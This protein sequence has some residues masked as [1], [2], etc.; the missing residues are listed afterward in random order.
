M[1]PP[2]SLLESD[3]D[4]DI[5]NMFGDPSRFV[6][7]RSL[8]RRINKLI[9][10]GMRALGPCLIVL[11]VSIV[12]AV[13]YV[14]FTHV[15][16]LFSSWGGLFLLVLRLFSHVRVAVL[17]G[18]LSVYLL[19]RILTHYGLVIFTRPGSPSADDL[20]EEEVADLQS[21][22]FAAWCSKV[23]HRFCVFCAFLC[24]FLGSV[25]A[26]QASQNSSLQLLQQ[27]CSR[28]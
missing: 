10:V 16:P 7:L 6:C 15:L 20:T 23:S 13:C 2:I 17:H 27:M 4:D 1:R 11:G 3:E 24:L 25:S 18:L 28:L 9:S 5:R 26:S 22:G 8:V 21:S 19:M 12:C 14:H